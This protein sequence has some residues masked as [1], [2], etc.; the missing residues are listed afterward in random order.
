M[1][2]FEN[3]RFDYDPYPIGLIS[4][5]IE[6]G[7]YKSLVDSFPP[8]ELFHFLPQAGKKYVL[9]EKFNAAA[10][11]K[12]VNQ[13]PHWHDF[14]R[15]IK[16]QAFVSE[17]D[18]MLRKHC[19]DLGLAHTHLASHGAWAWRLAELT[20]G[21]WPRGDDAL[22]TRFE[23]SMLPADGGYVKPHTDTPRKIITL[24]LFMV[25]EN[26]WDERLG[27]GLEIGRPKDSR[28]AFNWLNEQV[29]FEHVENV[30]TLEYKPNQCVV[31][32]KTFNSFHS[33]LPMVGDTLAMRRSI[34]INIMRPE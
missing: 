19:I 28:F 15:W 9:S 33:V 22:Q 29:A 8:V 7:L 18:A 17:I 12:F 2:S 1:F 24:V 25:N 5:V 23:F 20:K 13:S 3:A 31:F 34:T 27:G 4:P 16:S 11:R 14:H 10:Y 6:A 21:R 30:R 32:I 26:E